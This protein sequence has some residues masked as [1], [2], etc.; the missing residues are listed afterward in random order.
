[1]QVGAFTARANAQKRADAERSAAARQ[2]LGTPRVTPDTDR[3]GKPIFTVQIGQYQNKA[4]AIDAMRR[5]GTEAVVTA[6]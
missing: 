5:L 4:S 2:G 6:Q 3:A 1:V